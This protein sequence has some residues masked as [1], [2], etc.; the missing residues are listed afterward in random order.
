MILVMSAGRELC[1]IYKSAN[2]QTFV[3]TNIIG[4]VPENCINYG[5]ANTI[6]MVKYV[7]IKIVMFISIF[8][9]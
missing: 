5:R 8:S 7:I 6:S 9:E 4:T 3:V 2:Y 1:L